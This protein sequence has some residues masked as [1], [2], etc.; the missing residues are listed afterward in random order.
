MS[1]ERIST[2]P[3]SEKKPYTYV[4]PK[5][6][7]PMYVMYHEEK[8]DWQYHEPPKES[9]AKRGGPRINSLDAPNCLVVFFNH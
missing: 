8:N 1:D 3:R 6:I 5:I 7:V 4:N 9:P 2:L